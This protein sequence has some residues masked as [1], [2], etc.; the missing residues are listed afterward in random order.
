MQLLCLLFVFFF[1]PAEKEI[2]CGVRFETVLMLLVVKPK[3]RPLS[4]ML[5]INPFH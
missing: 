3:I 2:H 4:L 1:L 5:C